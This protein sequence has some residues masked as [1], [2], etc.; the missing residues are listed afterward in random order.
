MARQAAED[1]R[2][3]ILRAAR[4]VF[5]AQGF[6]KAKISEI[7]EHAGIAKGTVYLYFAS[8]LAILE[9]LCDYYRRMMADTITPMLANPDSH[10]ALK[11]AVHAA[12]EF[13]KRERDLVKLLD[14]Q[15]G[16]SKKPAVA[17][18]PAAQKV[19]QKFFRR[20]QQ[21]GEMR[22]YD[23]QVATELVGGFVQWITRL[24]LVWSDIDLSRYEDTAIS[25]L[26]FALFIDRAA[27]K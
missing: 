25:M 11:D 26:S 24:C 21:R 5:D 23:P 2:E 10:R 14:L 7:A 1:R 22:D 13:A 18:N 9:A 20:C 12:L 6:E 16:L 15:T 3:D 17:A 27:E 8:K 19:M 4:E